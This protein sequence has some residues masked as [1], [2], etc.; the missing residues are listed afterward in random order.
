MAYFSAWLVSFILVM[1]EVGGL[2]TNSLEIKSNL[3]FDFISLH[4]GFL[5][6]AKTPGEE[7]GIGRILRGSPHRPITPY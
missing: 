2:G 5:S 3:S 1:E 6:V 7:S 4:F